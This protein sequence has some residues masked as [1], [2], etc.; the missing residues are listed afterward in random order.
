[1]MLVIAIM[2]TDIRH[3]ERFNK[4]SCFLNIHYVYTTVYKR[5]ENSLYLEKFKK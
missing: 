2:K 1:M 3:T 5:Y 4:K